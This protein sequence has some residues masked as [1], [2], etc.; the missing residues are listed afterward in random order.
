MNGVLLIAPLLSVAVSAADNSDDRFALPMDKS[1][2]MKC[3]KV[4]LEDKPGTVLRQDLRKTSDGFLYLFE[5]KDANGVR[6]EL[7]CDGVTVRI[8]QMRNLSL[9]N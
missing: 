3:R 7:T 5:I 1:V 2:G 6:F 8:I 9:R 4:A